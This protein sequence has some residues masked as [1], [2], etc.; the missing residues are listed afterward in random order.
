VGFRKE[1][2]CDLCDGT[3]ECHMC[4]QPCPECG[5]SGVIE[6]DEKEE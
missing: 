3:G 2:D 4:A 5:G 6:V 1:V